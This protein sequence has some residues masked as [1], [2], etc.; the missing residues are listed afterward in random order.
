MTARALRPLAATLL[1]VACTVTLPGWQWPVPEPAVSRTFG[2]D[3]GGYLLRGVELSGGAQPVYPVEAGVV[4]GSH[5]AGAGLAS[6]LGSYVVVEHDQAFRSVYAHLDAAVL[7]DVGQRVEVD[8]QIGTVGESG[9]VEGRALR[10]SIIDLET[11]SYVNP[12]LLLP[13]LPDTVPPAVGAVYA[14]AAGSLYD[15]GQTTE[16][17]PGP[18]EVTAAIGDRVSTG[19]TGATVAPY[20]IR[21]FVGGQ[22]AFSIAMDRIAV[23][24]AATAIEPGGAT[25]EVLYGVEGLVRLGTL[26]VGAG[27]TELEIVTLDFAGNESSWEYAITG[28]TT[29]NEDVQ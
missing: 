19:R 23:E 24:P 2:Q 28:S 21:M 10:L 16:L 13:D 3:A 22:E 29:P 27:R 15:L 14:R 20:A 26:T 5:R 1:A 8:T 12:M 9:L 4:V 6:G 11:G 17:P 25:A 7:P 18:Y